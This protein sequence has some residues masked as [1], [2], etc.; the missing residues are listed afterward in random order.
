M[1]LDGSAGHGSRHVFGVAL[2]CT[3]WLSLMPPLLAE[4]A[5]VADDEPEPVSLIRPVDGATAPGRGGVG[6]GGAGNV[7][8]A[9]SWHPSRSASVWYFVEVLAV[10][11]DEPREVFTGYTRQ[12]GIRLRLDAGQYAW[13]VLAVN[14]ARARYSVSPWWSFTAEGGR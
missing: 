6:E 8:I 1:K 13:R 4:E 12:T 2:A 10:G 14:R 5:A 7:M 9:F 11:Q 3:A